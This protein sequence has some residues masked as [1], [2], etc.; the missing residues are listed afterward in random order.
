MCEAWGRQWAS[1]STVPGPQG[2]SVQVTGVRVSRGKAELSPGMKALCLGNVCG[3]CGCL[4][5][6]LPVTS[7]SVT[8]AP[9]VSRGN[10]L[11]DWAVR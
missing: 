8:Q 4:P 3:L 9:K 6:F 1:S 7:V 5:V 2:G 11:L 10:S